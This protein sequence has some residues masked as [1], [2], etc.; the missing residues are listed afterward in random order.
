M[1]TFIL[2]L[3]LVTIALIPH[4]SFAQT[5]GTTTTSPTVAETAIENTV[6]EVAPSTTANYKK[7][8][9]LLEGLILEIKDI[10]RTGQGA[11]IIKFKVTRGKEAVRVYA[12]D[13]KLTDLNTKT[14]YHVMSGSGT[15][16][17][18]SYNPWVMI[19][20]P[21]ASLKSALFQVRE[22]NESTLPPVVIDLP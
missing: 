13:T 6:S 17:D 18:H 21:P 11:L 14:V 7:K 19:T 22:T 2:I 9:E 3:S 20:E 5:S 16:S 8:Y 15:S 4:K 1:R 12:F 10:T